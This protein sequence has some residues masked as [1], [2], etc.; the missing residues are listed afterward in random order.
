MASVP[1]V[2]GV[3]RAQAWRSDLLEVVR[4]LLLLQGAILIATT[5]EAG[6]FAIAFSGGLTPTVLMTAAAA[7]AVFVAR[8]RL[9]SERPARRTL[10]V[11]EAIVLVLLAVDTALSL[12]ITHQAVPPVAVLTRFVLPVSVIA[13]VGRVTRT[14]HGEGSIA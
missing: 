12:I 7:I 3:M 6:L 4:V 9:C 13:L 8:A 1:D 2:H 14:P 10:Y 11:V 5:L